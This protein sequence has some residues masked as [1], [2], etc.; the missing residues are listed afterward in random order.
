MGNQLKKANNVPERTFANR[1]LLVRL[2]SVYDGDTVTIVTRLSRKEPFYKY[3]L[4]LAGIDAP[5]RKPPVISVNRDLIIAAAMSAKKQ[6]EQHIG[7]LM[8][9]DF[10][11]E[12]KYGRL[13]GTLWSTKSDGCKCLYKYKKS[14]NINQWMLDN[15]FAIRYDGGAKIQFTK[16]QLLQ[17]V[18]KS[19][20]L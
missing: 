7:S 15:G 10:C 1:T 8:L 4:R 11:K 17:I 19:N 13:M 14:V 9:V 20:N 3:K 5:E 6:L 18:K 2:V 16:K 12:D